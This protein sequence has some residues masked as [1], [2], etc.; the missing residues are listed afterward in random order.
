MIKTRVNIWING[1]KWTRKFFFVVIF[2]LLG[3]LNFFDI[4]EFFYDDMQK[5]IGKKHVNFFFLVKFKK[6]HRIYVRYMLLTYVW[7]TFWIWPEE[8]LSCS[9]VG[10][11]LNNILEENKR[12]FK[13]KNPM[14]SQS[15]IKIFPRKFL[16]LS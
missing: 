8:C 10:K 13:K 12:K 4:L 5:I 16:Y 2:I 14:Q 1:A 6:V 9:H 3:L 7:R 15:P 11:K